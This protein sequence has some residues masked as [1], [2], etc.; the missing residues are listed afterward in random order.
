MRCVVALNIR[1]GARTHAAGLCSYLDSLHP[2]TVLDRMARQ[3]RRARTFVSWAEGRGMSHAALTDGCTLNG[4]FLASLDPFAT[5]SA[6]PTA[7]SAG[8]L[9]LARFPWETLLACYFPPLRAKAV[10]FDQC[11]ELAA[12]H[13]AAPFLLAGDLNTGNQLAD[14]SEGAGKFYCSDHFDRLI[15][16]G[17]LSD[18]WRLTNGVSREWTWRSSKGNGFRIDHAFGNGAF[19]AAATAICTYD[20]LARETGLTD[21][22]AIVVRISDV[23]GQPGSVG[24]KARRILP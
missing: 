23:T 5:E 16:S 18:L 6:T 13:Q 4:V 21:H 20:R 1:A 22:S 2:D 7:H 17:G 15:S 9:M 3:R 19:V 12:R 14:R 11:L 10:F 8:C 24:S